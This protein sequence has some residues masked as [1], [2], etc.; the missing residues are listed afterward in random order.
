MPEQADK[1]LLHITI[2]KDLGIERHDNP[3]LACK[4]FNYAK[5]K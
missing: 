4:R 3:S 2:L 1:Y 5:K